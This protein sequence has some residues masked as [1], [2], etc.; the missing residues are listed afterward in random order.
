[1]KTTIGD[2]ASLVGGMLLRGDAGKEINGFG[3]LDQAADDCV[4]FFGNAKYREQL[5]STAAGVVLVPAGEESVPEGVALIQVENPIMAFDAIIREHGVKPPAFVAGVSSAAFVHP[6]ALVDASEVSIQPNATVA[7]KARVG[8]GSRI[9]SGTVISEG[10]VIGEDCEI[11]PN[12]TVREGCIIG[13]RVIVHPGVVIGGDGFGF[14][15]IDGRHQ[16]IEQLGIVRVE[17]D[18]EIGASTTID[19]AR[20]GETVIGEGTKIDNQVQIGHNCIIG[21]HCIIVAQTGISGSTRIG[22]YVTLAAQCG[23]AGHIEI[24]DQ[25]TCGGRSGVIQSIT[26][27]GGTYFGYPARPLKEDRRE[28]MR[29]KQLGALMKRVKALEAKAE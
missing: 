3:S 27:P 15:F 26:E 1:M 14:E 21:K 2:I 28:S 8:K 25:T 9:G 12:V 10:A 18:V 22:N 4:S 29:I 6:E 23:I 5:E 11:G 16:K 19:R 24:A 20:F 17:S 13:D 7:S